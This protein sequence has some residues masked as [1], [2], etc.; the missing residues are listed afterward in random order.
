MMRKFDAAYEWLLRA[1]MAIASLYLFLQMAA[2]VY[3]TLSRTFGWH[4]TPASFAFIEYGFIYIMM[5]GSPW[6]VRTRGHVFI[7]LITGSVSPRA[8]R[9][10]SRTIAVLCTLACIFLT[11]FGGVVAWQ[12]FV[13]HEIDVRS[14]DIPRWIVTVSLPVGF[15]L[16]AVEFARFIFGRELMHPDKIGTFG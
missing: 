8:R 13:R 2:I 15:G 4:Y 5:L 6:L 16:M 12:D 7:E 11:V 9:W 3:V 10:L 1:M 14:I